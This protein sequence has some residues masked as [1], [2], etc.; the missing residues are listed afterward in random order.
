MRAAGARIA[1]SLPE[2]SEDVQVEI[3]DLSGRVIRDLGTMAADRGLQ[4]VPWDGMDSRGVPVG[5]GIYLVRVSVDH[6][7]AGAVKAL[8]TR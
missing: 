5:T 3:Y 4:E 6:R 1:F 8:V 7:Q 2:E